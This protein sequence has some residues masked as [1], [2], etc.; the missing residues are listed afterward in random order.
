MSVDRRSERKEFSRHIRITSPRKRL[1]VP[2]NVRV[3]A[4]VRLQ[5]PPRT[6]LLT[7]SGTPDKS[8]SRA[9]RSEQPERKR[10]GHDQ[11]SAARVITL[12]LFAMIAPFC[13]I[14]TTDYIPLII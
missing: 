12:L 1:F 4:T 2:D 3:C 10:S 9:N 6:V 5:A 14:F 13:L 11:T 8:C 7:A